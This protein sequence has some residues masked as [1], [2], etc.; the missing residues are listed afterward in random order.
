M[1]SLFRCFFYHWRFLLSSLV[2]W[3]RK[4]FPGTAPFWPVCRR[5]V[6]T[7][8]QRRLQLEFLEDRLAPALLVTSGLD[9]G[10]VGTLRWA[11]DQAN[12]APGL[13]I[14]QFDA[15]LAGQTITVGNAS[16][17][18]VTDPLLIQGP[19]ADVLT[20]ED[21]LHTG[22]DDSVFQLG[23]AI[24]LEVTNIHIANA[25]HAIYQRDTGGHFIARNLV[26]SHTA[27]AFGINN[28]AG[29][30]GSGAIDN[31]TI[32]DTERAVDINNGGS[33]TITNSI[34][35]NVIAAYV[36]QNTDA[37]GIVPSHNLLHAVTTIAAAT[38]SG[39]IQADSNQVIA[40]PLFV[41]RSTDHFRLQSG[42]PAIDTGLDVGLPYTGPAPDRGAFEFAGTP[43]SPSMAGPEFRI[44][45]QTAGIQ[46]GPLSSPQLVGM[47]DTGNCVVVWE[48]G[49]GGA[50]DIH[51]QRLDAS[52]NLVGE[53]LLVNTYT[54][55]IS[56]N[57]P[58]PF[59]PAAALS[60]PGPAAGR[61]VAAPASMP[62]VLMRRVS[63]RAVNFVSML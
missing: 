43:P 35:D 30:S 28:S 11:I 24:T 6:A 60:S 31:A 21:P 50:R 52:G 18:T 16:L 39:V 61:M 27:T 17:P 45:T 32:L 59:F 44:N 25:E 56:M 12:G 7:P 63:G 47:D 36:A 53:E 1:L 19:G 62:S 38:S 54:V 5:R 2:N 42:S 20:I 29:N 48:T 14:I 33:I 15:G 49:D 4:R 41:D 51:A 8:K 55:G 13:D 46:A 23:A 58:W 3:W 26:V 40:D 10:S 9:D 34:L 37:T 57:R 22:P